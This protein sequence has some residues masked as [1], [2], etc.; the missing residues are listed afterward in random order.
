MSK[1]IICLLSFIMLWG[2]SEAQKGDKS[3]AA[4]VLVALPV[5]DPYSP[6]ESWNTGF[7]IEG[8]GQYNFSNKSSLL[9]QFQ[10][11]YFSS[12]QNYAPSSFSTSIITLALKG[13]YRYDFT[14]NG[15]YANF[16]IGLELKEL[17]T[18]A[19]LGVGKR[20]LLGN[21]FIDAGVEYTGGYV[22]HYGIRAV[23]S[24]AQKTKEN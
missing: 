17:L 14:P 3:I 23:Y 24:L 2:K 12:Q 10:A 5:S 20:F 15:F 9:L 1:T 16:L 18:P 6:Y 22:P 19:T 21:H 7:G 4:G 11:I 13:G 8:I